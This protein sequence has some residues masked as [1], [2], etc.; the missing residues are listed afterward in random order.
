MTNPP[1][2]PRRTRAAASCPLQIG[3]GALI[4]RLR[5]VMMG[6]I[7]FDIV[8]TLLGQPA[9]YWTDPSMVRE[10][11]QWF[12]FIMSQGHWVSILTDV[13]YLTGSFLLVTYLPWRIALTLLFA[14]MLGHFMGGASWLCFYHRLGVQALVIYAAV[15]G[16]VIVLAGFGAAKAPAPPAGKPPG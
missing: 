1:T 12:H 9:S 5:W 3:I 11:N 14:L 8:I 7:L 16:G 10:E 13:L 6:V 4:R 2:D 15:L